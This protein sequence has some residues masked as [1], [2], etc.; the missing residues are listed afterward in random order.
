MRR[1]KLVALIMAA[2]IGASIFGGCGKKVDGTK[3]NIQNGG[4]ET[5]DLTGWEILEGKAFDEY[6]ITTKE[7]FWDENIPF[8]Y[9]GNWHLYG[10]GFDEATSEK[11]IGK[12]K[13]SIFTLSGDGKISFKLGA[14]KDAEK[15]YIAVYLKEG[16]KLI[17][18][19][20]NTEFVDPGIA[21]LEQYEAGLAYTNNYVEY[22]LDLKDYLGKEMYIVINDEDS[23]GDFG[24]LNV[25]DIRTYYLDGEAKA[26]E[27]GEKKAKERKVAEVKSESEFEVSNPGFE[28]GDLAGWEIVEG[29][30]FENKGVTSDDTWWAENIPYNKEGSY[31]Y[32]I[33]NEAGVGKLRSS[34][35][36]L[37]ESGWISF[38]LGGGKDTSKCY[39]S[40]VDADS[41]EEIARYGNTEFA[42][43]NFPNVDK[44]LRL[45]N[46]VEYK[47]NLSEHLGKKLYIE[48]VDN[49]TEDWGLMTFDDFN[50]KYSSAPTDGI[51]AKNIK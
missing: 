44:G 31:L 46:M 39:I 6:S 14:G 35:F 36:T 34:I 16:D 48:I 7:G 40:V 4:F 22:E 33:Y 42:D 27:P 15:C 28:T 9:E 12:L 2:T 45:A 18:K 43:V 50:T 1:E 49:D 47:A 8:G 25:D 19:Q 41:K 29:N 51:E 10:L 30:A 37:G 21:N 17:A 3:A 11:T 20:G 5:G 38:R 13:S 32:G 23:D 26:Q 24:F